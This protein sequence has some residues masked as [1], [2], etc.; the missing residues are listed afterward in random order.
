MFPICKTEYF[1]LWFLYKSD[2]RISCFRKDKEIKVSKVHRTC[3][4]INGNFANFHLSIIT[5]CR[6][7]NFKIS[8]L[9]L[10]KKLSL[11]K[12]LINTA[13][14]VNISLISLFIIIQYWRFWQRLLLLLLLLLQYVLFLWKYDY[15]LIDVSISIFHA[16]K[17]TPQYI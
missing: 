8:L 15:L 1:Y 6:K 4:S 5:L 7:K 3:H 17:L 10:T 11:K 12:A 13:F 14:S 9:P 2:S 16:L